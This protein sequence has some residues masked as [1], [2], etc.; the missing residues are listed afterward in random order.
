MKRVPLSF[1]LLLLTSCATKVVTNGGKLISPEAQGETFKGNFNLASSYGSSYDL[2]FSSNVT[3]APLLHENSG[4]AVGLASEIGLFAPVDL[5][6]SLGSESIIG[7]KWQ[8]VGDT[9]QSAKQGSFSAS[10]VGTYA[11]SSRKA[12]SKDDDKENLPLNAREVEFNQKSK[13]FGLLGGVRVLDQLLFYAGLFR[14]L[15]DVDGKVTTKG[16]GLID[17]PFNYSNKA[18]LKTLGFIYYSQTNIVTK[19]ELANLET[20]WSKTK[21]QSDGGWSLA[22]GFAW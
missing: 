18:D 10:L 19:M 16:H 8:F 7:L 5:I 15:E 20:R 17:A 22:V 11:S 1:F 2:N 14:I 4:R 6:A 3:N 21:K 12:N 13:N 9:R